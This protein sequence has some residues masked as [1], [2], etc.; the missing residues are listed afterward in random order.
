MGDVATC[1]WLNELYG[2]DS[3]NSTQLQQTSNACN[4]NPPNPLPQTLHTHCAPAAGPARLNLTSSPQ[5][6]VSRF[7]L[8]GSSFQLHSR[9]ALKHRSRNDAPRTQ[10]DRG[11]SRPVVFV[12]LHGSQAPLPFSSV[13]T[14]QRI[15][16]F[17]IAVY[18]FN[19]F[20]S[21]HQL[22]LILFFV[23]HQNT[24]SKLILFF[25]LSAADSVLGFTSKHS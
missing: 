9:R 25:I 23:L 3:L 7:P 24:E 13:V 11:A 18:G 1:E 15:L 22:I 4:P 14:R 17:V 2:G 10:A 8:R 5:L 6:K 20:T 12:A 19:C 16:F 21:K